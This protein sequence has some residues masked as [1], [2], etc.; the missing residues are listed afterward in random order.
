MAKQKNNTGKTSAPKPA[1]A[2]PV[3]ETAKVATSS[4]SA[5]QDGQATS[6][7]SETAASGNPTGAVET[8]ASGTAL[9]PG[10]QDGDANSAGS[11]TITLTNPT[12]ADGNAANES[13]D[14]IGDVGNTDSNAQG[15][16]LNA[17]QGTAVVAD[18]G[19]LETAAVDDLD[20]T[21]RL[22][23]LAAY[24]ILSPFKHQG[25]VRKPPGFLV[26]TKLQAQEGIDAGVLGEAQPWP[27]DE[28]E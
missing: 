22:D 4:A 26:L 1:V 12:T 24:P 13:T 20:V 8:A 21:S 16:A 15:D 9:A 2:K 14:V 19:A 7:G 10:A 18:S 3:A 5:V 6:A 25:V 27:M 11:E 17:G 23:K 28:A